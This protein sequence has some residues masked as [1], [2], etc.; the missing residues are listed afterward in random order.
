MSRTFTGKLFGGGGGRLD[1]VT[2]PSLKNSA[3]FPMV[4]MTTK[5][6]LPSAACRALMRRVTY[7]ALAA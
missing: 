5:S 1:A 7:Y 4:P 3:L 6:T 2:G